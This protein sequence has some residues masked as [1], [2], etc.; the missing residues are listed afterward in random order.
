MAD[1]IREQIIKKVKAQLATITVANGYKN[2]IASVQR[3]KQTGQVTK[4]VPYLII[5]EGPDEPEDGPVAGAGSLTTRKL[6]ISVE[7][8][9]RHDEAADARSSEEI[10]NTLREDLER[11]LMANRTWDGLARDTAPLRHGPIIGL[12][13]QPDLTCYAET[14]LTY[15]HRATDPTA[16]T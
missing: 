4:D 13:G 2:T 5:H 7:V 10:V 9:M 14:T 16:L 11:A 1:S 3:F 8:G 15:R 6:E 12:E